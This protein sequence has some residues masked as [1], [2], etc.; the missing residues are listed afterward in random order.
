M[1]DLL[2]NAGPVVWSG[3]L[4]LIDFQ[5]KGNDWE[6]RYNRIMQKR[7]GLYKKLRN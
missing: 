1:T 3:A 7:S 2:S 5:V 4:R 6:G